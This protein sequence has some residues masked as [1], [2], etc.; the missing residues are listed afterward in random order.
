MKKLVAVAEN[1]IMGL[2]ILAVAQAFMDDYA[3]IRGWNVSVRRFLLI[4]G[5][6]F[7]IIFTVEF[8]MRTVIHARKKSFIMYFFYQRGWVD[9][10]S[11]VLPLIGSIAGL[12]N[13][14]EGSSRFANL[15][16]MIKAIRVAKVL[17]LIRVLKIFGKIENVQSK[18]AQRHLAGITSIAVT[19]V[20]LVLLFFYPMN[21]TTLK[22]LKDMKIQK[23]EDLLLNMKNFSNKYI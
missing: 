1:L 19:A 20:L 12:A 14:A 9:L 16:K 8:A 4:L 5:F 11:S 3:V 2:I 7:D 21:M 23:Y 18:M 22:N 15:L 13:P 6:I 10:C 17:R